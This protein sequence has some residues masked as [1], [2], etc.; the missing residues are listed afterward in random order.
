MCACNLV[1]I[2]FILNLIVFAFSACSS[3]DTTDIIT[4]ETIDFSEKEIFNE[5]G[6][7]IKV[8][9]DV[10][11][12][13]VKNS[14]PTNSETITV[15]VNKSLSN[16]FISL[17]PNDL[18]F[19]TPAL[20]TATIEQDFS[21]YDKI[22]AYS[23]QKID[24]NYNELSIDSNITPNWETLE[25]I[26][27]N[28][29]LSTE[30]NHFSYVVFGVTEKSNENCNRFLYTGKPNPNYPNGEQYVCKH[31]LE[32]NDDQF[33]E[34]Y[35][36]KAWNM[37]NELF[38]HQY[39]FRKNDLF[40]YFYYGLMSENGYWQWQ[41]TERFD[42]GEYQNGGITKINE[43]ALHHPNGAWQHEYHWRDTINDYHNYCYSQS[44]FDKNDQFREETYFCNINGIQV[45]GDNSPVLLKNPL[46]YYYNGEP[47]NIHE[48]LP[49]GKIIKPIGNVGG[50]I[51]IEASAFDINGLKKV[52]IFF[53]NIN[54][55]P[56]IL[57][58]DSSNNKC[59]DTT[60]QFNI[61]DLDPNIYGALEGKNLISMYVTDR[62]NKYYK[63]ATNIVNWT[64]VQRYYACYDGDVYWYDSNGNRNGLKEQCESNENCDNGICE[65]CKSENSYMCFDNDVYW[66]DSC[67][68]REEI[69]EKC[70]SNQICNNGTCQC[71]PHASSKCYDGDVYWYDSCGN[72]EEIKEKCD[73]NQVCNNGSCQCTPHESS[74]CYDGDV[75]WYDSCGNRE[76]IKERCD[77]NQV[78]S[79]GSCQCKSHTSYECYNGN[80]Y[81]YNSCDNREEV[82]E[83]CGSECANNKCV[84]CI[85]NE[86][87][88]ESCYLPGTGFTLRCP[89][90]MRS[91]KCV[92]NYWEEWSSCKVVSGPS[93]YGDG[94]SHCGDVI[95][96]T[97]SAGGS[98]YQLNATLSKK[99]NTKFTNDVDLTIYRSAT[100]FIPYGCVPTSNKYS[101]EFTIN[102]IKFRNF[103]IET[104]I[105]VYAKIISPCNN[106]E[107]FTFKSDE[108][109]IS[110]CR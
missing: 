53:N 21:N 59:L 61:Y 82:K 49:H 60:D 23:Y 105:E 74:K 56:I 31:D 27:N 11:L 15:G 93:Y 16:T 18:T 35:T 46:F 95:C 9:N 48:Y 84:E 67:G 78:C 104:T 40:V 19:S 24:N 64:P 14:L 10:T 87:E 4:S 34:I 89:P 41:Y 62:N 32:N 107:Y 76:E 90:G 29:L 39:Q 26:H 71:T 55:L 25:I 12:K 69:K 30:I 100:N 110:R 94:G 75:Y 86:E 17:K 7:E 103:D 2:I 38:Q 108:A 6:G 88:T 98:D 79:N 68:N 33:N 73:S 8:S 54:N 80:V 20:L 70:A 91:R 44:S 65:K 96:L 102:P 36:Y 97:I 13:I 109:Y 1:K 99:D 37:D 47:E 83:I 28:N 45:D 106:N 50:N 101:Y 77:S 81:W 5:D 22:V 92:N 66:Y 43:F 57:C 63:V 58:D 3:D 72:K 85:T 51:D 52:A 42:I